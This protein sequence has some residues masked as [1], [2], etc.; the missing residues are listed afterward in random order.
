MRLAALIEK[1]L[2]TII[3]ALAAIYGG[4]ITGQV[5]TET[6]LKAHD[7]QLAELKREAAANTAWRVCATRH[8]DWVRRGSVGDAPCELGGM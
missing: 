6:R 4:F 7:D 8:I 5:T 2:A 3:M 1:H